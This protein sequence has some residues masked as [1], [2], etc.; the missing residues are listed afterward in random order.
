V[1]RVSG[2]D[3]LL[4]PFRHVLVTLLERLHAAGH[5]PRVHET[6]RSPERSKALV[7]QGVSRVNGLSMH[8]YRIAA[9]VICGQHGW[10]CEAKGCA[11]YTR[12]GYEAQRLGLTW[13]GNWDGDTVTREQREHDLPHV[14]A[15]PMA[16]Q[17][18][19]RR[20][21][22]VELEELLAEYLRPVARSA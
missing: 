20:A 21:P 12:L 7:A 11:Y 10:E 15:V 17:A 4:P 3:E 16:V 19:A 2:L 6:Y 13:G 1:K 14:Q 9:D 5:K 8:C 18:R 22:V